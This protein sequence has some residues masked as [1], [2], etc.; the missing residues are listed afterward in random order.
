MRL[1]NA[2]EQG[3]VSLVVG[4][5]GRAKTED[6]FDIPVGSRDNDNDNDLTILVMA[7]TLLKKRATSC[8]EAGVD[9]SLQNKQNAR[10][11]A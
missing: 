10:F 9:L 3:A 11:P 7:T 5:R 1:E 8:M 6:V 4:I 2:G